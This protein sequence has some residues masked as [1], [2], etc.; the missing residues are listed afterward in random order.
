MK[1][2][3]KKANNGKTQNKSELKKYI[4]TALES[5]ILFIIL[6]MVLTFICYKLDVDSK[7]HYFVILAACLVSCF[8][9]GISMQ[10][11]LQKRGIVCGLIGALP[12]CVVSCI[13]SMIIGNFNIGIKTVAAITLMLLSGVIAGVFAVNM[14]R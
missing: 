11:K 2:S 5:L 13:G 1:K 3:L 4:F 9:G 10:K 14:R 6:L 7:Y 8:F 12:V